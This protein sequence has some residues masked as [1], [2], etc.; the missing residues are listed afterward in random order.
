MICRS[1][2]QLFGKAGRDTEYAIDIGY[3]YFDTAE[4]NDNETEVGSA[5]RKKIKEG[6]VK[7]EDIFIA[8]KLWNTDH[9]LEHVRVACQRSGEKLGLGYIDLYLMHSPIA[10]NERSP[11]DEMNPDAMFDEA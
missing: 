10:F 6:V 2:S 3:R 11:F 1:F 4:M 9:E 5:I 7:R 8:T